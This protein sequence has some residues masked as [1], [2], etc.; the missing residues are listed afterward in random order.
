METYSFVADGED[1]ENSAVNISLPKKRERVQ[2]EERGRLPLMT[3]R[4]NKVE[5]YIRAFSE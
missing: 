2:I 3:K 4:M 5:K 1:L